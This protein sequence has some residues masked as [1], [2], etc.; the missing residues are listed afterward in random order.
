MR[1]NHAQAERLLNEHGDAGVPGFANL[2][3]KLGKPNDDGIADLEVVNNLHASVQ[4]FA[5]AAGILEAS[6]PAPE[7]KFLELPKIIG[8]PNV[9]QY[10][11]ASAGVWEEPDPSTVGEPGSTPTGM[12]LRWLYDGDEEDPVVIPEGDP[13]GETRLLV[14]AAAF[15][16]T[17][18]LRV[19][20][21]AT[22]VHSDPFGPICEGLTEFTFQPGPVP[23][24]TIVSAE[25]TPKTSPKN[26]QTRGSSQKRQPAAARSTTAAKRSSAKSAPR[27]RKT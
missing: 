8:E 15:G 7:I 19:T 25:P 21:G 20:R 9:G 14:P 18:Q 3:V 24:S 27:G 6:P 10:V 1:V 5:S 4:A 23:D 16:R 22:T 17:I 13:H 26:T 12:V 2:E 11:D